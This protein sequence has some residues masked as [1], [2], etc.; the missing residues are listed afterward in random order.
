MHCCCC[1]CCSL[2][3]RVRWLVGF[4][5]DKKNRIYVYIPSRSH[6]FSSRY[7][8]LFFVL[9]AAAR[10]MLPFSLNFSQNWHTK[11]K[12]EPKPMKFSRKKVWAGLSLAYIRAHHI[13]HTTESLKLDICCSFA[14]SGRLLT[15]TQLVQQAK[16][17]AKEERKSRRMENECF[18]ELHKQ[19]LMSKS[20]GFLYVC[21]AAARSDQH[22]HSPPRLDEKKLQNL[23][24]TGTR[25][26]AAKS[27]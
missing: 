4:C 16:R 5:D 11:P 19:N 7:H 8:I 25:H 10:A 6:F 24:T 22:T 27:S 23:S 13:K 1:C 9:S 12:G 14:D 18:R 21:G 15:S 3:R 20:L 17:R 2:P 26:N